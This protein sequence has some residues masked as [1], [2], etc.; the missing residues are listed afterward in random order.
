MLINKLIIC[1]RLLKD[2]YI[3]VTE[4][5]CLSTVDNV[6][7]IVVVSWEFLTKEHMEYLNYKARR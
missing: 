2:V 4:K 6:W 5:P 1:Q 3:I 7:I